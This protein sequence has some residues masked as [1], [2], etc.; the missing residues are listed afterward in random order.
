LH[1]ISKELTYHNIS[2]DTFPFSVADKNLGNLLEENISKIKQVANLTGKVILV[3][4]TC[5]DFPVIPYLPD[6]FDPSRVPSFI[7]IGY[8]N[9]KYYLVTEEKSNEPPAKKLKVTK[10]YCGKSTKE[11][12]RV[13]CG[14]GTLRYPSR[15]PCFLNGLSCSNCACKCCGN[16]NGKRVVLDSSKRNRQSPHLKTERVKTSVFLTM[17]NEKARKGPWSDAESLLLMSVLEEKSSI[18]DVVKSY[19]DEA[20]VLKQSFV[21]VDIKNTNQISSKLAHLKKRLQWYGALLKLTKQ[22]EIQQ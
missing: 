3:V 12:N 22:K 20:K 5:K 17:R 13:F 8:S 9:T 19:N 6:V 18:F 11:K 1:T 15:C 4:T 16:P 14:P 10:C 2:G 7:I 21:P